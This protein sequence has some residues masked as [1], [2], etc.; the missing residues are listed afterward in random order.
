MDEGVQHL[1]TMAIDKTLSYWYILPVKDS[2]NEINSF[3][4]KLLVL[5][6]LIT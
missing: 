2:M 6:I 1:Q 3:H 5:V 4:S